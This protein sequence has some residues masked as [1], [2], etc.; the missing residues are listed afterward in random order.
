MSLAP[1]ANVIDYQAPNTDYGFADAFFSAAS[2]NT[3]STVSTSWGESE[4]ILEAAILAGQEAAT[5]NQAFDEAFLELAAQ[6]QSAFD[7]SGDAGAYDASRRPRHHQPVGRRRTRTA[8]TSPRRA[9]P[10][11]PGPARSPVRT[12]RPR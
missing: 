6:G 10:R 3:A 9:A 8:R 2:Q 7:A 12:V 5:Y 11:C 1:G 4:T